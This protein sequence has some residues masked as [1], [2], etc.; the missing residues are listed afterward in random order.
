MNPT[1]KQFRIA[2]QESAAK[3]NIKLGNS[4]T[5]IAKTDSKDEQRRVGIQLHA[6]PN[7]AQQ[8]IKAVTQRLAAEGAVA[9]PKVSTA[10]Y[11]RQHIRCA[12][13]G[14]TI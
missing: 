13:S 4:W 8:L 11:G 1:S 3:L 12:C 14:V 7:Q 10:L 6:R 5:D 9:Y 2:V